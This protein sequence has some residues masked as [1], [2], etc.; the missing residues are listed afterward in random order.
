[1]RTDVRIIGPIATAEDGEW[2]SDDPVTLDI[3]AIIRADDFLGYQPDIDY[4]MAAEAV[5]LFGGEIVR[6]DGPPGVGDPIDT[7][8]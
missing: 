8:Y 7:V 3:V 5:R 6:Y 4:V 1:M 2:S